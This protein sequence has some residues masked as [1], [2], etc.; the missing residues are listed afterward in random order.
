MSLAPLQLQHSHFLWL[1]VALEPWAITAPPEGEAVPYPP[2]DE[3]KELKV[4][5]KL[6][7]TAGST[8]CKDFAVR[9]TVAIEPEEG[10]KFP[11]RISTQIEGFFRIEHDGDIAERKKLVAV[12]GASILYSAVREQILTVTG[13]HKV[14]PAMIPPYSFRGYSPEPPPAEA[15]KTEGAAPAAKAARSKK[16]EAAGK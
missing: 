16:K 15:E 1:I 10:S 3:D 8:D 9:L 2:V 14:G 12:N 13:R 6:G 7:L 11:Y 5:L 4:E